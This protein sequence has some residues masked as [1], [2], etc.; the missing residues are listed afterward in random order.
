[1]EENKEKQELV[2]KTSIKGAKGTVIFF[3][4]FGLLL[5][6]VYS[7]D[8]NIAMIILGILF[9]F[10]GLACL[11]CG[12]QYVRFDENGIETNIMR[13]QKYNW[14]EIKYISIKNIAA[15]KASDKLAELDNL[16]NGDTEKI[17]DYLEKNGYDGYDIEMLEYLEEEKDVKG[18]F[19]G[20]E[21]DSKPIP[22]QIDVLL[23]SKDLKAID[24][25][26]E[27][28][29]NIWNQYKVSK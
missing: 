5:L 15:Q 6:L 29:M 7:V 21:D 28:I 11:M 16:Y 22:N 19:I 23:N 24:K 25:I 4:V 2:I 18:I 8:N 1:M 17:E 9:I 26:Y 12:K 10:I 3:V 20:L 13:N 27:S 14:S